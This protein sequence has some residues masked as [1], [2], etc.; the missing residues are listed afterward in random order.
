MSEEFRKGKE[1]F[2]EEAY[3]LL[4]ELEHS[5]LELEMSPD[6]K[7]MIERAF[8]A[9][10]T[11]KG[12]GSMFGFEAI[13]NLTHEAETVYDMV[14]KGEMR[15]TRELIDLTFRLIDQIMVMIRQGESADE[16]RSDELITSFKVLLSKAGIKVSR[17]SSLY[18]EKKSQSVDT[19]LDLLSEKNLEGEEVTYRIYFRP[20]LEIFLKG[21]NPVLMLNELRELGRCTVITHS[22]S[23]PELEEIE[24]EACYTYWDVLLTTTAGMNAIKD[25]F[26]FIEDNCEL[27]IDV[28]DISD[29]LDIEE[30]HKRFG[31]LILEKEK[32]AEE[33]S[34]KLLINKQNG[35]DYLKDSNDI[36]KSV[37]PGTLRHE[38][39]IGKAEQLEV[40]SIRVA[41]S[42]LD[43]LVNL[44]GE[45]VTVQARLSQAVNSKN[46][47]EML[48]IAEEIERL[49]DE[50]RDSTMDVR[51][52]PI[53]TLFNRFRRLV[54]DLSNEL[55]KQ[56]EFTT[57]GGETELDKNVIEK[58]HDP[59][60]HIIRN[61]I[62]HGIENPSVR[63]KAGKPE[64]GKVHISAEY[65][66]ANVL[67]KVKDDGAG[68]DLQEI[69]K[70]AIEKGLIKEDAALNEREIFPILFAPG[71][72]TSE[73][74]T[75]VSGRG[76]GL[77]VV[78]K[79]IDSLRGT[80]GIESRKGT[81]TIITLR[82]PLTL[83]IIE[84]LLVVVGNNQYILPL[85]VVEECIELT[86]KEVANTHGRH[87]INVRGKIVPYI[88]LREFLQADGIPPDIEQIV[89]TEV[90][91]RRI[92]LAV[93]H[94]TGEHQTVIKSLGRVYKDIDVVSGATILGNGMVAIILNIPKIIEYTE[95]EEINMVGG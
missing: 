92:G 5:L 31:K 40:S 37:L 81:G 24:P 22:E 45:M 11:I 76:V 2:K 70:N 39:C 7:E 82:I 60:V 28:V 78:K 33:N 72:S 84:G 62:D 16:S 80:A 68:I 27:K 94:V 83:A 32:P 43:K 58:L 15:V 26:I 52:V 61:S 29:N 55:G 85:S 73:N 87:M 21:F 89:I 67:I 49:T 69:M 18:S 34:E 79:S 65:A 57:E 51:L 35:N 88:R 59:L 91:G 63:E 19:G 13:A 9:M 41:A 38:R 30:V 36:T 17:P 6:N 3:E 46:D 93:D 4:S 53:G 14:R 12:S 48:L 44:V 66:D 64:A 56:V 25:I 20:E 71:F 77:D 10:H 23:I 95:N 86:R 1:I 75:K 42:K 50:L 47:P 8:R 74:I 54:R 90:N